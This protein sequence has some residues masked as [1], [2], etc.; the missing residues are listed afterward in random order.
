MK[1]QVIVVILG[2]VILIGMFSVNS[3]AGQPDRPKFVQQMISWHNSLPSW[4]KENAS[5]WGEAT[6][7]LNKKAVKV[8]FFFWTNSDGLITYVLN[9]RLNDKDLARISQEKDSLNRNWEAS[10]VKPDSFFGMGFKNPYLTCIETSN[11]WLV[12]CDKGAC[13]NAKG[14]SNTLARL[15]GIPCFKDF[16]EKERIK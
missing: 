3:Q 7:L 5:G 10:A 16:H 15:N 8:H 11:D 14:I 12:N 6:Y 2:V 13:N 4:S 1:K 9:T